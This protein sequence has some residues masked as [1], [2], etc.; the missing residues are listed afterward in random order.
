MEWNETD[1]EERDGTDNASINECV[2]KICV[3][4]EQLLMEKRGVLD[5][6]EEGGMDSV[7]GW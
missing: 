4:G 7:A 3:S 2:F 5:V 6:P 1:G